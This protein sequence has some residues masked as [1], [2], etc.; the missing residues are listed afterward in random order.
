MQ[1]SHDDQLAA[2]KHKMK[3][4]DLLTVDNRRR[5]ILCILV[6]QCQAASGS[7]WLISMSIQI[8]VLI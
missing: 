3:L 7:M 2:A 4:M 5:T 8:L 6:V 1:K